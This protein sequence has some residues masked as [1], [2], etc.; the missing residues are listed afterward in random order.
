MEEEIQL[1]QQEEEDQ[2]RKQFIY[3]GQRI[4]D[5]VTRK[6]LLLNQEYHQIKQKRTQIGELARYNQNSMSSSEDESSKDMSTREKLKNFLEAK[7]PHGLKELKLHD[8][9]I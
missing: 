2:K 3:D 1:L 7:K 5:E 6:K 4:V 8:D 9:K